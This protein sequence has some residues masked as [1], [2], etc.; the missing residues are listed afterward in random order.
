MALDGIMQ[1]KCRIRNGLGASGWDL[2]EIMSQNFS[3]DTEETQ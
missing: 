2:T 3:E 1:D